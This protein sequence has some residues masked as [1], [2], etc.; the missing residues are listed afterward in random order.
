[1]LLCVDI[2]N[3]NIVMGLYR[4]EELLTHWRISTDQ[5]R[6]PDEYGMLLI[7]LLAHHG[8]TS[9][10]IDGIAL[11]S[12]VPPVTDT[13]C[14]MLRHYLA[15]KP[16]IV[17]SGVKTGVAIRYDNPREVGADRVVNAAA[18][19]TL[20]G[21]PAC[22][23]DFGTA[24]TFDALSAKGE[25]LGGAIAPGVRVAAEA[26]FQRTAKLP[27]IDLQRP[28]KAIGTN[29]VD[30][31]RAG[32]LFGYVGLVEGMVARFRRELGPEMRVIGTGGLAGVI[33]EETKV[34]EVVDP[35]LTLKGLRLIY[36]MNEGAR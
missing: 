5:Q 14:E 10:E 31:M 11:A 30:S 26:L 34:I 33:A 28:K 9:Q 16:F 35:W 4:G 36:E 23:V 6:M 17:D 20:Y 21:G 22:I 12:V 25:Y 8:F 13:F 27:R 29:T 2:G 7:A 24:T 18:A 19:Y 1:M 3:T 32:I 15:P